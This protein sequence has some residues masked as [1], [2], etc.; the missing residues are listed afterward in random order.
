MPTVGIV[1]PG[2]M[3]SAVGDTLRRGGVRVV[4]TIAGRSERNA[5]PRAARLELLPDLT[6]CGGGRR[7]LDRAA[8]SGRGDRRRA[9]RRRARRRPERGRA[10]DRAADLAGGRRLDLR[11]AAVGGGDDADL[12]LGPARG[13]G[14]ALPFEGVE[15]VVVGDEVGAASAVKMSTASVY[16]GSAACSRRLCARP[17]TTACSTTCSTTSGDPG[18]HGPPDRP[19]AQRKAGPLR[20]RDAR[21]CRRAGGRRADAGAVRGDGR[22][23]P[24]SRHAARA[25]RPLG[26]RLADLRGLR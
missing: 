26:G 6:P 2:A 14:R 25:R 4:A 15:V 9:H 5:R 1:S 23:P 20:R 8:G 21:D 12:P 10:R 19:R 22:S 3:G 7:P 24:R 18:R 13:R 17:S 16:K 11:A